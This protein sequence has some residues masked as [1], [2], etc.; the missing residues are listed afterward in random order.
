LIYAVFRGAQR[1]LHALPSAA[2]G[3]EALNVR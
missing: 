2:T 1:I 3:F